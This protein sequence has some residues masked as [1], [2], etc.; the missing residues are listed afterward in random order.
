MSMC[1]FGYVCVF[2]NMLYYKYAIFSDLELLFI[3]FCCLVVVPPHTRKGY[4]EIFPV[5]TIKPNHLDYNL[6]IY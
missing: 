3:L 6:R 4:F 2:I 1:V 5:C